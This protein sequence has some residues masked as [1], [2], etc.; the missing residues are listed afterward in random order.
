VQSARAVLC[1]KLGRLLE[2]PDSY[3]KALAPARQEPER[4][5]L[6]GRLRE[7]EIKKLALLSIFS[8]RDDGPWGFTN[9]EF[10]FTLGWLPKLDLIAIWISNPRKVPVGRIFRG[11]FDRHALTLEMAEHISHV[12][13]SIINL[14]GSRLILDVLIRGHN[15][16]RNRSLDLRV[17]KIPTFKRCID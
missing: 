13:H 9:Q 4:G 6:V 10:L 1:P 17:F 5:F 3:E 7:I 12:L 15:R 14:T 8:V 11:L 16:P 2:A